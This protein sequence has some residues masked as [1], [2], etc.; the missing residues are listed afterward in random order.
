MTATTNNN[1]KR[2]EVATK[3]KKSFF[4]RLIE[5]EE[6]QKYQFSGKTLIKKQAMS[7]GFNRQKN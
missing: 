7:S 3:E 1:K 6:K 2:Q 4:S 5:Y